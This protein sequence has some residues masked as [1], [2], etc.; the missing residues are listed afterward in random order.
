MVQQT[1]PPSHRILSPDREIIARIL[2]GAEPTS[3][4]LRNTGEPHM[5]V[6]PPPALN[7][8]NPAPAARW[9]TQ[10]LRSTSAPHIISPQAVVAYFS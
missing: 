10:R 3:G 2:F 1:T 8:S 6:I 9:V 5:R 4:I 7:G